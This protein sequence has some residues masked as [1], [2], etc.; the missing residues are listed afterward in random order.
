MDKQNTEAEA[1][2]N[3]PVRYLLML[4]VAVILVSGFS[5]YLYQTKFAAT[6]TQKHQGK[7]RAFEGG[8]FEASGVAQVRG[9]NAVLFV[10]D[11]RPGEVLWMQLDPNGNQSGDIKA[12]KLGVNIEDPEGI[13]T[14]GD[15]FYIVGSQ[16]KGKSSDRDGIIRFKFNPEDQSVET[17]ETISGVKRFLLENITELKDLGGRKAK[18]DG[19]NIE[20]IAWDPQ[21]QKL[22]LGLR[23]PV[24]DGHA[25]AIALKL[26]DPS[27]PFSSENLDLTDAKAIRLSLGGLGIRSI[28]FDDRSKVFRIIAGATENQDKTDFTLWEWSGEESRSSL[29]EVATFDRK[30]K[31]EGV[32]HAS[33]GGSDFTFIVFD[34]SRYLKMD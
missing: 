29:R 11:G 4:L 24:I 9:T 16:S 12:V 18:D 26:R 2:Y 5:L 13:T 20:G 15:H 21:G 7:D 22:L 1:D 17:V 19:L 25:L 34:T 33:I 6:D 8:K 32:T 30:L 10:D 28:E 3:K 27:G 23:S 14:D 31:P